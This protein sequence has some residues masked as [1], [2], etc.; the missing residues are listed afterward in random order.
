MKIRT[1]R[2]TCLSFGLALAAA[3]TPACGTAVNPA[4][5]QCKLEALRVLPED[6]KAISSHDLDTLAGK[7]Q[8]CHASP[9]AGAP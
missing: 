8:A 6:P 9:D 1:H 5:V 7:L 4:L 3:L 2:L